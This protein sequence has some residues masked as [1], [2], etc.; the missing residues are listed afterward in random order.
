MPLRL[1]SDF[2][3]SPH[4]EA[5][6]GTYQE[7]RAALVLANRSRGALK[8]ESDRKGLVIAELRRE[9]VELE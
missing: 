5:L 6:E 4:H 7:S 1:A 3:A 9:L 8:A 2:S